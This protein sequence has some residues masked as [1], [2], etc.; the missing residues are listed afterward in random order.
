MRSPVPMESSGPCRPPP[1]RWPTP[2]SP[3][4]RSRSADAAPGVDRTRGPGLAG[5]SD[6]VPSDDTPRP[7]RRSLHTID[8][9]QSFV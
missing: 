3:H 8:F 6:R 7:C 4:T 5:Y 2:A 9:P 1:S